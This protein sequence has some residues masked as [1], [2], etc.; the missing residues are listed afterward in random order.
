MTESTHSEV[1]GTGM[2]NIFTKNHLDL[3]TSAFEKF[4]SVHLTEELAAQITGNF[5][6][7]VKLEIE[8]KFMFPNRLLNVPASYDQLMGKFFNFLGLFSWVV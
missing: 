7:D 1:I 3:K 6:P 5:E 4:L 2:N 8:M